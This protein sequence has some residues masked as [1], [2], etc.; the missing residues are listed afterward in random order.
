MTV[1]D[2]NSIRAVVSLLEALVA[3]K[4]RIIVA[5]VGPPATGKSTFA[6]A[7]N[8]EINTENSLSAKIVPMDGFHLDN[9]QLDRLGLRSKKGA[10]ETFDFD[11][12]QL[13]LRRIKD[14][15][16]PIYYPLFDRSLDKAI[17]G[18]GVLF[19]ETNIVI[20]EG[21]YLLL[22]ED[23]WRELRQ[24]FDYSIY[25]ETPLDVLEER[26]I[27]RWI[28][29]DHTEAEARER[30]LSNDIPNARRV[31]QNTLPATTTLRL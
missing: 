14:L 3:Q 11:G 29:N 7:L 9:V 8:E 22:D 31:V 30:A 16:N 15:S 5:V 21:N 12:F 19:P 13:L 1:N 17:G 25:L 23:P 24:L 4:P 26:L 6:E 10:P 2:T 18:M 27:Q 20:V 28:D